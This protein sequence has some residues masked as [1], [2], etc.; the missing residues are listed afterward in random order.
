MSKWGK[1]CSER[2]CH[3]AYHTVR[4]SES[5]CLFSDSLWQSPNTSLQL[6]IQQLVYFSALLAHFSFLA[7]TC[8]YVICIF[9]GA[10]VWG[11]PCI[12]VYE[13]QRLRVNVF[14]SVLHFIYLGR[15]FLLTPGLSDSASLANQLALGIPCH[16]LKCC[17]DNRCP[18]HP[19]LTWI[20]GTWILLLTLGLQALFQPSYCP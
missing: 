19:D 2:L 3:I 9:V 13:S 16:C 10:H 6:F 8:A 4:A 18:T 1:R 15:I 5:Q 11:Y 14:L 20:L 7:C 12:C 17:W